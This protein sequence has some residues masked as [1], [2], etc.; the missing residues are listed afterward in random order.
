MKNKVEYDNP[1]Y[2]AGVTQQQIDELVLD[3]RGTEIAIKHS[4]F[5]LMVYGD[6]LD[7]LLQVVDQLYNIQAEY[8]LK[9]G[10]ASALVRA[11]NE[12]I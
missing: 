3:D 12:R 11:I 6:G 9:R 8:V 10:E 7:I 4:K 2:P 1:W 5:N